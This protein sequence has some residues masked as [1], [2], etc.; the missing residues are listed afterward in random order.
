MVTLL[1]PLHLPCD[2]VWDEG[3]NCSHGLS[4]GCSSSWLRQLKAFVPVSKGI[5]STSC[6]SG[7]PRWKDLG[8][9][10]LQAGKERSAV[11]TRGMPCLCLTPR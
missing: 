4:L 6:P 3:H 8:P 10:T 11:N 9:S 2:A 1:C 7:V 5:S